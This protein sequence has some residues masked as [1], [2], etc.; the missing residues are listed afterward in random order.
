MSIEL[1][2]RIIHTYL[3]ND[4]SNAVMHSVFYYLLQEVLGRNVAVNEI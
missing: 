4:F 3:I 2:V 1:L